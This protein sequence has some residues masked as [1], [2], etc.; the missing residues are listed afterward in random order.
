MTSILLNYVGGEWIRS[1]ASERLDVTNPANGEAIATVV[2]T[3]AEEVAVAVD[4][5]HAAF[6]EW[7]RVPVT[8]RIQPLFRFKMLLEEHADEL[9][10]IVTEECGK[11]FRESTGEL[12]RGI[13]NV[14]VACGTPILMQG[15]NNEDIAQGID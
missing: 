6:Q 7:R 14:E 13:E 12:R 4:A 15:Y 2:L 10:A 9:A 11:T 5:A 8:E 3:P 1:S